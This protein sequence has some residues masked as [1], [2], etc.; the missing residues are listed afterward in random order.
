MS[1]V[2]ARLGAQSSRVGTK[3]LPVLRVQQVADVD[4]DFDAFDG[5]RQ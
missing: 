3:T 5:H 1:F 4:L 2:P